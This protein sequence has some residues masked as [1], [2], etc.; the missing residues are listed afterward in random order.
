MVTVV[1]G[2]GLARSCIRGLVVL[3][4]FEQAGLLR[5]FG[6]HHC[7]VRLVGGSLCPPGGEPCQGE[8]EI[9][10]VKL[11]GVASV[12][13]ASFRRRDVQVATLLGVERFSSW[14]CS[15]HARI[16]CFGDES[17]SCLEPWGVRLLPPRWR[18]YL[19]G[20]DRLSAARRWATVLA[21]SCWMSAIVRK[22]SLFQRMMASRWGSKVF[23]YCG[24]MFAV[25]V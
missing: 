16:P 6:R 17:V 2:D 1:V 25:A 23:S 20:S 11:S 10:V 7:P 5:C 24:S 19:A 3:C 9:D 18:R 8:G 13:L 12:E 14:V 22:G 4:R 21:V 15:S